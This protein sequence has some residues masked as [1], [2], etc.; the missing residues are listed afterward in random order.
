MFNFDFVVY[1]EVELECNLFLE[2]G[3]LV[4]FDVLGVNDNGVGDLVV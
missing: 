3:D 4:V 2:K 1:V